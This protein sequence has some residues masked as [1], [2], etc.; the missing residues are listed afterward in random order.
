LKKFPGKEP[1]KLQSTAGVSSFQIASDG[2]LLYSTGD[3]STMSLYLANIQ[4]TS[5][6]TRIFQALRIAAFDLSPDGGFALLYDLYSDQ[7]NR[8]AMLANLRTHQILN[9]WSIGTDSFL[10]ARWSPGGTKLA[11]LEKTFPQKSKE[12]PSKAVWPN[13]HFFIL[14]I[15]SGNVRDYGVGVSE[16][17]NWTPDSR[18]ILYTLKYKH[19]SLGMYENGIFIMRVEDGKEL[20]Q[21]SKVSAHLNLNMSPSCRYIVWQALDMDTFFVAENPFR[22]TMLQK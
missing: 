8:T 15:G 19:E 20:G 2:T 12:D 17:F 18:H 1:E 7:N 16:D 14:D 4:K 3:Y 22:S 6:G 9:K 11:Y 10:R 21:L 13:P 5:P